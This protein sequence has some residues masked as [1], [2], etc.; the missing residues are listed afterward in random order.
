[1]RDKELR[2]K[3][4]EKNAELRASLTDEQQ[5]EKIKT[6]RGESKK[7]REKLEKRIASRNA[8]RARREEKASK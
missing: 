3:I 5:L 4:A 7:E 8:S 6:R 1:M 2:R